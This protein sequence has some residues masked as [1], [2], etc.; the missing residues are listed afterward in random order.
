MA[1]PLLLGSS[2]LQMAAPFQLPLLLRVDLLLWRCVCLRLVPSNGPTHYHI[3]ERSVSC[4]TCSL[5]SRHYRYYYHLGC[6]Y[7]EGGRRRFLQTVGNKLSDYMSSY[8]R[9]QWFPYITI[10]AHTSSNNPIHY[11]PFPII[12]NPPIIKLSTYCHTKTIS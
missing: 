10:N 12:V 6:D 5:H 3:K 11:Q 8:P 1:I 4:E 9:R 7:T 2:P